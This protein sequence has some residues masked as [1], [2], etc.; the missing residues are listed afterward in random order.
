[1][2]RV[3]AEAAEAMLAPV[4]ADVKAAVGDAVFGVDET[5]L[6]HVWMGLRN[7]RGVTEATAGR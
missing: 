2:K 1:M 4:V 3:I 6:A 5:G 7:G